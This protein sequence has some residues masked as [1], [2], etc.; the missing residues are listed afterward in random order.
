MSSHPWLR[1]R[2]AS[3]LHTRTH[4]RIREECAWS[5]KICMRRHLAHASTEMILMFSAVLFYSPRCFTVHLWTLAH[6]RPN[7]LK[8]VQH[9]AFAIWVDVRR[10]RSLLNIYSQLLFGVIRKHQRTHDQHSCDNI[11]ANNWFFGAKSEYIEN[12]DFRYNETP[13]DNKNQT[14]AKKRRYRFAIEPLAN[15]TRFSFA[16]F[17]D[18][19]GESK[20][21]G[22]ALV[23]SILRWSFAGRRSHCQNKL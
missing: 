21:D 22:M 10:S 13:S 19:K 18:Q 8:T 2:S 17:A 7:P 12:F 20:G 3:A 15:E 14:I 23:N 1:V 4:K 11:S 9:S 16:I 5:W 6:H